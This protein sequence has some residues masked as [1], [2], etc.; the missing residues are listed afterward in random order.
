MQCKLLLLVSR[1]G[2]AAYPCLQQLYWIS[3]NKI[4]ETTER[5]SQMNKQF[6]RFC[7][8]SEKKHT[9][10]QKEK[11]KHGQKKI[12][13][14]NVERIRIRKRFKGKIYAFFWFSLSWQ[15][16]R[17]F[18]FYL[19]LSFFFA[20]AFMFL[21]IPIV[22]CKLWG[23]LRIFVNIYAGSLRKRLIM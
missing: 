15:I 12:I 20:I 6:L 1:W 3:E 21:F 9:H 17:S 2:N 23:C 16:G 18:F 8:K 14:R 10:T 19:L 4:N 7:S 22:G 11:R 5:P 13:I